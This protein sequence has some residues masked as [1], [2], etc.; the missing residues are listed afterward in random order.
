MLVTVGKIVRIWPD[1]GRP[2]SYVLVLALD[3]DGS[4]L[5]DSILYYDNIET[6]TN[7]LFGQYVYICDPI[8]VSNNIVLGPDGRRTGRLILW[9]DGTIRL[10][11]NNHTEI[12][13][14]VNIE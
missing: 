4:V 9:N 5:S 2:N 6:L 8:D 12:G 11:Q 7:N 3:I 14:R 13:Q 1:A 10:A